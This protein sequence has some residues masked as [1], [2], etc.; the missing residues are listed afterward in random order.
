MALAEMRKASKIT[1]AFRLP[2][3]VNASFDAA[4][5]LGEKQHR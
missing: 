2:K 5:R 3:N 4:H 1:P